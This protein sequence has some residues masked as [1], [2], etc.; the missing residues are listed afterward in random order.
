MILIVRVRF[1]RGEIFADDARALQPDV[2]VIGKPSYPV[3]I[4]RTVFDPATRFGIDDPDA[5]RTESVVG[6]RTVKSDDLA[7]EFTRGVDE[8]N[9]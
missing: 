4:A 6:A 9:K 1:W 5:N 3:C 7:S 8:A 2:G